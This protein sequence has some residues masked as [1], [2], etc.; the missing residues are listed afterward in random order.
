[1][2]A[3]GQTTAKTLGSSEAAQAEATKLRAG[4]AIKVYVEKAS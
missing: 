3:K 2:R 1:M 4:K